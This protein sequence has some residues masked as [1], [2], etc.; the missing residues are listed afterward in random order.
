MSAYEIICSFLAA[1]V[2]KQS[3]DLYY[4]FAESFIDGFYHG[5]CL[6]VEEPIF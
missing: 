2:K 6:H 3:P 4:D 5:L 1:A